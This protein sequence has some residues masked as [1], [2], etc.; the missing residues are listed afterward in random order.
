MKSGV[1]AWAKVRSHLFSVAASALVLTATTAFAVNTCPFDNGGSDAVNDSVVLTRYALGITG[2]PLVA[3]TRYAS[4]DP[5]NVKAN[6]E[7]V[8][9][10]LDMN[11][12]GNVDAVDATI[13]ARHLS[14]FQGASLTAGLAL[15]SGTR[16]TPTAVQSFLAIGCGMTGGTV[17]S[18]LAGTGLTG[19]T[20]T[21]SGTIAADTAYLQRRVTGSCSVGAAISAIAADGSITCATIPAASAGTVT[22]VATG[23]GLSGGPITGSGTIT[24]DTTYVQRRVSSSCAAGSSIRAI[25]GDGSVTC[26]TA[27]VGDFAD[28]YA[29]MPAD[30]PATVPLGGAVNF[31]QNGSTSG[32]ITR[33]SAD[34]FLLPAIGTYQIMFQ[35]SAIESGQLAISINGITIASTVVGRAAG[36]SQIVG[37]S[38]LTTASANAMLRVVNSGSPSS[39]TITPFAGGSNPV[40]AHLVITRLR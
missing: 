21:T 25:A 39:L 5:A 32:A 11:G 24:A 6:I 20:I 36:S 16:S 26:E 33:S 9:C 27:F 38:L 1:T 23:A 14:G 18:I 22:N 8:G 12:D 17:T 10:A 19:G 3:S 28:F 2:A 30:N 13:I 31:P 7:C 40:S 29:L 37:M 15:G 4:L 35:V 34:S